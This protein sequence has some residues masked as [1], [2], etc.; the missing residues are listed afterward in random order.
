MFGGFD[1][2]GGSVTPTFGDATA[3]TG[4]LLNNGGGIDTGD[5]YFNTTNPN[6]KN[7]DVYIYASVALIALYV[8]YKKL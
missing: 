4:D 3:E 1:T 6:I 7:N 2:G 5:V 8:A